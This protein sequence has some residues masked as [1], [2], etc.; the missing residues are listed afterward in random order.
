M[1]SVELRSSPSLLSPKKTP[2]LIMWRVIF[3]HLFG[4]LWKDGNGQFCH[5]NLARASWEPLFALSLAIENGARR[6][7]A[8]ISVLFRSVVPHRSKASMSASDAGK[9][10]VAHILRGH[11]SCST[12]HVQISRHL[13]PLK[14]QHTGSAAFLRGY[15]P[16]RT[17]QRLVGSAYSAP[18][19][20][21]R[22]LVSGYASL[23]SDGRPGLLACQLSKHAGEHPQESLYWIGYAGSSA[24]GHVSVRPYQYG[25]ILLHA[26]G[27]G[28]AST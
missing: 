16:C 4:A 28:P 9:C 22:C 5:H 18:F 13:S 26:V 14:T 12:H 27:A 24:P 23:F 20:D 17:R 15:L 8:T 6:K 10:G 1:A 7:R 2:C 19:R 25:S 11:H 21:S 3:A